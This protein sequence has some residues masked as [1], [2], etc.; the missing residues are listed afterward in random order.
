[1]LRGAPLDPGDIWPVVT[2]A[3]VNQTSIWETCNDT[4]GTLCD[5]T[6]FT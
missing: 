1:V 2:L 4:D 5:D 3:C 6:V